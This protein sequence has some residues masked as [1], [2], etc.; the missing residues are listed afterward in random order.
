[1]VHH[2]YLDGT[3]VVVPKG[4]KQL[5]VIYIRDPNTDKVFPAL[6]A[7]INSKEEDVYYLFLK[8]LKELVM[9][10]NSFDCGLQYATLDF[11]EALQE[12]FRRVF[13]KLT[14][15]DGLFHYKQ[16]LH[17]QA[18]F[19]KLATKD[20]IEETEKFICKLAS[21]SWVSDQ[22]N[23]KEKFAKIK[24][25]MRITKFIKIFCFILKEMGIHVSNLD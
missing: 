15:I 14:I 1:M 12:A 19:K 10:F 11:E 16:A 13:L 8:N 4:Y 25:N 9:D 20:R 18:Q 6:F 3:F 5:L 22:E 2:I 24:K 17:R 21:L 7:L 23:F